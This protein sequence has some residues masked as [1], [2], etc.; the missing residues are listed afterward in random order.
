MAGAP[1]FYNQMAPPQGTSDA[2]P[3]HGGVGASTPWPAWPLQ[4]PGGDFLESNE[5]VGLDELMNMMG[6]EPDTLRASQMMDAPP[7]QSQD[8]DTPVGR[9]QRARRSPDHLTYPSDQIYMQPRA[10]RRRGG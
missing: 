2:G 10:R 5:S 3:S 9:P 1:G 8:V 4:Q 7:V 6:D